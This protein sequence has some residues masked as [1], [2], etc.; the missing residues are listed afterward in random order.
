MGSFAS[1]QGLRLQK[2]MLPSCI[3]SVDAH[4]WLFL[5]SCLQE[6]TNKLYMCSHLDHRIIA[7]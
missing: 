1:E 6:R 3:C 4:W 7:V 2:G 5:I